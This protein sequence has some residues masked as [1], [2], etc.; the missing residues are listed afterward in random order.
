[1][2]ISRLAPRGFHGRSNAIRCIQAREDQR[3]LDRS[4]S[5]ESWDVSSFAFMHPRS[6]GLDVQHTFV[7]KLAISTAGVCKLASSPTYM[8]V[9]GT[10]RS[11]AMAPSPQIHLGTLLTWLPT[12]SGSLLDRD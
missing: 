11:A 10:G 12:P 6:V 7:F 1:M 4:P 9:F 8:A 2:V 3:A 5:L